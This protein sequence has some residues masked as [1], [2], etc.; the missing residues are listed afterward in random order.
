M[1]ARA[2]KFPSR[3]NKLAIVL[4]LAFVLGENKTLR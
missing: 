2:K 4:N 3:E 1:K